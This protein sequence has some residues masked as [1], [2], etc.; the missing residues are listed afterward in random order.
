MRKLLGSVDP[1]RRPRSWRD[2]TKKPSTSK[3]WRTKP[4]VA[5]NETNSLLVCRPSPNLAALADEAKM[6]PRFCDLVGCEPRAPQP[7]AFGCNSLYSGCVNSARL[8]AHLAWASLPLLSLRP[9][10][11]SPLSGCRIRAEIVERRTGCPARQNR[12][13]DAN[14]R[15]YTDTNRV[16]MGGAAA[17]PPHPWPWY[18]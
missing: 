6:P 10:W 3:L 1:V 18:D 9:E 5:E 14:I 2:V 15:F 12:A 11:P 16:Q 7:L 17:F 4:E 13:N 8:R